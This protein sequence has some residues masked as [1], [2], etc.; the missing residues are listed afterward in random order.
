MLIC[1]L[2][3]L[4]RLIGCLMVQLLVDAFKIQRISDNGVVGCMNYDVM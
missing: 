3:T 4:W 1:W 2:L